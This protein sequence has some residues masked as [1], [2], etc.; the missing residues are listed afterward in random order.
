MK[1]TKLGLAITLLTG[2]TV[3]QQ[4]LALDLYVDT[5]TQ[6]IFAEPGKG[7]VKLGAFEKVDETAKVANNNNSNAIAEEV[8]RQMAK[9]KA[10]MGDIKQDLELKTNELKAIEEHLVASREDKAKNDEKWFNKINMRGYTQVRYNQPLSGDREQDRVTGEPEL[11]SVGDGSIGNNRG[12]AFRRVRLV[13]SGDINDYISMYIQPDFGTSIPGSTSDGSQNFAQLRDAYFDLHLDKEHEYRFRAGQSK[14]P[15]GWENLQSS[16]NRL[17]LDRAD[18]LNSAV[19]SERDLGLM[20]YWTPSHVQ[21]LWKNLSKKGLKTSG[22]YGVLGAGIYNGSQ[23]NTAENNDNLYLVAH[24]SYP[25]ELGFMGKAMDGQVLEVGADA[26]SGR[27]NKTPQDYR[28]NGV[29]TAAPRVS[30]S[31]NDNS[32]DRVGVH[33]VLFPQPFGLQAEWNWGAGTT[34]NPQ[35][36]RIERQYLNGGYVMAMYKID[37]IFGTK[38]SMIPYVKWQTYDGAWKAATN[39]PRTQ[40]DEVEA[41]V[42]YQISK[43]LE[44]TL[45]YASMSRTN[46]ASATSTDFLKQASGDIIRT[47]LQVNY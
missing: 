17:T 21:K 32:E 37:E 34:L 11:R 31:S 4:A 3:A 46:V 16:Q 14:V 8:A 44:L 18:A 1:L 26:I 47:Q 39:A 35:A 29:N 41:G 5:K 19:P 13:F 20:A 33:A 9:E 24:S 36:N 15:F 2:A 40:V 42:E 12:F 28:F 25:V 22:D 43:A 38:G 23:I 30:N 45:A 27:F 10:E 7:R 6:Q